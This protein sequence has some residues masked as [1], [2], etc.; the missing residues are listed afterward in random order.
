L[1]LR[2][3]ALVGLSVLAVGGTAAAQ[4]AQPTPPPP[5]P[6]NGTLSTP[7][8]AGPVFTVPPAPLAS[9][10]A[11]PKGRGRRSAPAASPEASPSETPEPPQFQTM[12]GVWEVVIQPMA[13]FRPT[14]QHFFLVQKGD[15]LTG[16]WQRDDLKDKLPISG[17]FD[18]RLFTLTAKDAKTTYTMKGYA[19]NFGDMVGL[20]TTA[21][22]K[23][24]GTAFTAAHR[25]KEKISG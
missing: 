4:V 16:V 25:K 22:P 6:P 9:P 23:D 21:D 17:T 11:A 8:A 20:L 2:Q 13:K 7:T 24:K 3:L 14:Y 12:D 1:N 18:G 10:T 19:E 5:P 15:Q